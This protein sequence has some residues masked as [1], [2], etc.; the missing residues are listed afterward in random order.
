M[1]N[2]SKIVA[3][4]P[5]YADAQRV[6]DALADQHFPVGGLAIVGANLQSFEQITGRRGLARA[7]ASGLTSGALTGALIGWL[8]GL[9][10]IA[11]PLVSSLVMALFGVVVGGVIGLVL[12]LVAHLASGGRRDFSSISSVRAERYDVLAVTEI[13]DEAEL[14]IRELKPAS[15]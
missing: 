14:A 7:A 10:N 12:G 13:A 2:P 11:Q 4:Y 5:D 1:Q 15:R 9:F 6:V 3:S 8:L